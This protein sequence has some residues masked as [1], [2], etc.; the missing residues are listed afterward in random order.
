[1][2]SP[3]PVGPLCIAIKARQREEMGLRSAIPT[4]SMGLHK[5]PV[6]AS[7]MD[8]F[9]ELS[10][11]FSARSVL[12]GTAYKISIGAASLPYDLDLLKDQLGS[13]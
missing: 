4:Q 12:R 10:S 5:R 7:C 8:E 13:P 3:W 6:S 1:M 11:S 2:S 9:F